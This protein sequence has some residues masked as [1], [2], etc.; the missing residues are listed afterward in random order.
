MTKK[1]EKKKSNQN[2]AKKADILPR[3]VKQQGTTLNAPR[4]RGLLASLQLG[5]EARAYGGADELN[6]EPVGKC[7]CVKGSYKAGGFLLKVET[8]S[9]QLIRLTAVY[10]LV[11]EDT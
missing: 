5:Q 8:V 3:H 4:Q 9:P 10:D 2:K 11:A 7:V 1:K 6:S